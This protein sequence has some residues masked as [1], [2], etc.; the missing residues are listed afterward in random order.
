M[1]PAIVKGL[2]SFQLS[3]QPFSN[4]LRFFEG[5]LVQPFVR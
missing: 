1:R 3:L 4:R 5:T 2:C